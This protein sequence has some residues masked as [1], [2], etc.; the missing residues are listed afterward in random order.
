MEKTKQA[1]LHVARR[2]LAML[3][4]S[5]GVMEKRYRKAVNQRLAEI[6]QVEKQIAELE[7]ESR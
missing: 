2:R 6:A 4:N 1:P 7:S 5:I 3:K